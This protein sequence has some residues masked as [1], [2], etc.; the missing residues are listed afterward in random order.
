MINGEKTLKID[1]RG[2]I[3]IPDF[4]GVEVGE[5]LRFQFDPSFE[6]LLI[7]SEAEFQEMAE[8]VREKLYVIPSIPKVKKFRRNF[9][10]ILSFMPEKVDSGKRIHIPERAIL[11]LGLSNNVFIIGQGYHLRLCKDKESYEELLRKSEDPK[12]M[13]K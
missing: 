4:T 12:V 1:E 2:R 7:Y 5:N 8:S 3:T 6:S 13:R 11:R 10:G 9:F